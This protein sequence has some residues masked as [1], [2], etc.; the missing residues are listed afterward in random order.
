MQKRLTFVFLFFVFC[1]SL[2]AQNVRISRDHT[3]LKE[4][5]GSYYNTLLVLRSGAEVRKIAVSS[6]DAGWI[7]ISYQN[8]RGFIP[9]MAVSEA[10]GFNYGSMFNENNNVTQ[11]SISPTAYTAA[12]KGF[13]VEYTQRSNIT[14]DID[15]L[16]QITEF[17]PMDFF[18]VMNETRLSY[19]PRQGE[20]LGDPAS[21]H[22]QRLEAV[23]MAVSLSVLKNGVVYDVEMTKRLNI[24]ANILNRQTVNYD[25]RVYVWILNDPQPIA[26]AGPGGYIFVSSGLLRVLTDYREIVAVLAHE[27]GHIA[28]RHGMKTISMETATNNAQNQ[29]DELDSTG[30][31]TEA[32][33]AL[34]QELDQ[35]IRQAQDAC[36]LVRAD[37][38]EF[39]ADAAAMELLRRYRIPNT[40][41][42]SALNKVFSSLSPALN[43]Q[44]KSQVDR[45]VRRIN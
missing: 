14:V 25:R 39:E 11:M 44:Y 3:H 4:G 43:Q 21:V 6:D 7:E 16:Y 2:S 5:A 22:S 12:I 27:M 45:R 1:L 26:F 32:E 15:R 31:Y 34:S 20:L 36:A 40:F 30:I 10:G 33:L 8:R 13:L 9:A 28:L 42:K 37:S 38:D 24:I 23:G 17:R 35:I 29:F 18:S 41:L 19:F